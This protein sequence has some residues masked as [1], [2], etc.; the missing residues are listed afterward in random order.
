MR[1]CARSAPELRLLSRVRG[2]IGAEGLYS[3]ALQQVHDVLVLGMPTEEGGEAHEDI[4]YRYSE[5]NWVR[6]NHDN[7]LHRLRGA[8]LT[9]FT[10]M[11]EVITKDQPSASV[12]EL[13]SEKDSV[14]VLYK[15]INADCILVLAA[16]T[17]MVHPTTLVNSF[18]NALSAIESLVG[19]LADGGAALFRREQSQLNAFFRAYFSR[20][21]DL[22]PGNCL[23]S[24]VAAA[25][26]VS[27]DPALKL[28]IGDILDLL[29]TKGV[30]IALGQPD[31]S[32][33]LSSCLIYCGV[34]VH[35]HMSPEDLQITL[36]ICAHYSLLDIGS[37]P[38]PQLSACFPVYGT[39]ANSPD[40]DAFLVVSTL[41]HAIVCVLIKSWRQTK[42]LP[43][44]SRQVS[45]LERVT[46][47]VPLPGLEHIR[48]IELRLHMLHVNGSLSRIRALFKDSGLPTVLDPGDNTAALLQA[49]FSEPSRSRSVSSET[50]PV[51]HRS[52]SQTELTFTNSASRRQRMQKSRA[53]FSRRS[54]RRSAAPLLPSS[55]DSSGKELLHILV[56]DC[57]LGVMVCPSRQ[58][59]GGPQ[60]RVRQNVPKDFIIAFYSAC[61]HIRKLLTP[62]KISSAPQFPIGSVDEHGVMFTYRGSTADQVTDGATDL[63]KGTYWVVG[64]LQRKLPEDVSP[65]EIYVCFPD[66]TSVDMV[67]TAF[68]AYY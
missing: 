40:S 49:S 48:D 7:P 61:C 55:S 57:V 32:L 2:T 39:S 4:A 59:R 20:L 6:I 29:E 52:N 13:G 45:L 16:S 26:K 68:R 44:G 36:N 63:G 62:P 23:L 64:R 15:R 54:S 34:V 19:P 11:E 24:S 30:N 28:E 3:T 22:S 60:L 67:E 56:L 53:S 47:T 46:E 21:A 12:L 18:D 31:Q 37:L 1:M 33:T 14:T 17:A 50:G 8:L 27:C 51:G 58:G 9:I 5:A 41:E 65:C 42:F 66:G 10:Q 25:P 43:G 38:N 35:S